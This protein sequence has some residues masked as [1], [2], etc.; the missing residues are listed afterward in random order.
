MSGRFSPG[1]II[2][3]I[4][5]LIDGGTTTSGQ[6]FYSME[7]VEGELVLSMP[8]RMATRTRRWM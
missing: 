4:A 1:W 6:P 2:L 7:Y 5:R 8:D 3:L